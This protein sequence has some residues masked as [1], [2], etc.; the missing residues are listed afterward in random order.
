MEGIHILYSEPVYMATLL[1]IVLIIG[2]F[3]FGFI[4]LIL[5]SLSYKH[6]SMFQTASL[7]CLVIFILTSF[8]MSKNVSLF[9]QES[10]KYKYKCTI[11]DDVSM[12]EFHEKYVVIEHKD[13]IWI[14]EEK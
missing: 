13:D 5:S 1:S 4:F 14:I 11:S 6:E 2:C 3:A 8:L 7:I 12:T 9:S 10:G